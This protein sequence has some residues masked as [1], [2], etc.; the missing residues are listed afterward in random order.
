MGDPTYAGIYKIKKYIKKLI[1]FKKL[2]K[3]KEIIEE[4]KNPNSLISL[5]KK[6]KDYI[7]SS[8]VIRI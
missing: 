1:K 5:V 4:H 6:L 7:F 8:I 3:L 2:R